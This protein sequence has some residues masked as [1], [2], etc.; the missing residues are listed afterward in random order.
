M[1]VAVPVQM[2]QVVSQTE[3]EQQLLYSEV[4]LRQTVASPG[5]VLTSTVL[6]YSGRRSEKNPCISSNFRRRIVISPL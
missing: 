1:F 3:Q 6:G 5:N 2:A 4:G